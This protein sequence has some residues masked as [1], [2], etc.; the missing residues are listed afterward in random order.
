MD[1]ITLGFLAWGAYELYMTLKYG[2]PP[3][4]SNDQTLMKKN[5]L[6]LGPVG[7]GKS[8]VANALLG[9]KHFSTVRSNSS[10]FNEVSFKNGYK[11]ID[12]PGFSDINKQAHENWSLIEQSE[13]CIFVTNRQLYREEIWLIKTI[14]DNDRKK[15]LNRKMI[16]FVNM[17]DIAAQTM[18]SKQLTK[19]NYLIKKQVRDM[20]DPSMIFYGSSAPKGN[21]YRAEIDDLRTAIENHLKEI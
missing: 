6:L 21:E 3:E 15:K 1:P 10:S 11:I 13:V 4:T 7:T 9:Q 8:S 19:E 16:L 2:P 12:P 5:I 17:R 14:F 20:I 18:P